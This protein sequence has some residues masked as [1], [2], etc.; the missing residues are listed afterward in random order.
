MPRCRVGAASEVAVKITG[1]AK[2]SPAERKRAAIQKD[3]TSGANAIK[4]VAPAQRDKPGIMTTRRPY[5]SQK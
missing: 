1:A 5:M 3:D 4:T 2:P